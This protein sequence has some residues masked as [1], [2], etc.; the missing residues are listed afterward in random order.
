MTAL[1]YM[2]RLG[3]S[4]TVMN[5]GWWL[6]LLFLYTVQINQAN[7]VAGLLQRQGKLQRNGTASFGLRVT[8]SPQKKH[9]EHVLVGG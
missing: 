7:F 4:F 1:L 5:T 3:D 2:F 8:R 6:Q 9:N